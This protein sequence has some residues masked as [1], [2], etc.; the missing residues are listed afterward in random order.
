MPKDQDRLY[1]L[2]RLVSAAPLG[3]MIAVG[4]FV[5]LHLLN[6]PGPDVPPRRE[7]LR[8]QHAVLGPPSRVEIAVA[9]IVRLSPVSWLDRPLFLCLPGLVALLAFHAHVHG[10]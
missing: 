8:L 6:R 9:V 10:I 5:A 3:V 7:R 2:F 4:M 1:W